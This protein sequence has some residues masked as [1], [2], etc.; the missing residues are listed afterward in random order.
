M[1]IIPNSKLAVGV[2][3]GTPIR[4]KLAKVMPIASFPSVPSAT[5]GFRST[6]SDPFQHHLI[7]HERLLV[8]ERRVGRS[9]QNAIGG[10]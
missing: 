4:N 5:D 7:G 9:G 2:T 8:R 6:N 10:Q 3:V 1:L